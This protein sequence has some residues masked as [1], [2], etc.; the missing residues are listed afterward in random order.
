M[1][2]T[3]VP[4]RKATF[5]LSAAVLEALNR[6]VSEGAAESK[7]AF[8]ERALARE[9]TAVK[10][11]EREALWKEAMQDP[12]FLKD[13]EEVERDLRWADPESARAIE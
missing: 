11:A 5:N 8:V 1:S 6:A 3:R 2:R 13:L 4:M 9:L 12:L 7:N 10:R